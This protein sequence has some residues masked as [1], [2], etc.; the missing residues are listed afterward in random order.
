MDFCP[1]IQQGLRELTMILGGLSI[2]VVARPNSSKICSMGLQSGDLA[3]CSILVTLPCWRKPRISEHG[4]VWHYRL[5]SGSYPRNVAWQMALRCF[6]KCPCRA[7]R[8]GICRGAQ[9]AIWHHYEKVPR[10][11]PN[12]PQLGPYKPDTFAGSAHQVND[13]SYA[14]HLPGNFGIWTHH[15]RWHAANG[16]LSGSALSVPIPSG[17]GCGWLATG[18]SFCVIRHGNHGTGADCWWFSGQPSFHTNSSSASSRPEHL[19]SDPF[20]PSWTKHGFD[21]VWSSE[22]PPWT[23][24]APSSSG[25]MPPED[26]VDGG[27]NQTHA[28]SNS[29]FPHALTGKHKHFIPDTYKGWT[30]HY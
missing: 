20:G 22:Y 30:G 6:A 8:R 1:F 7:R 15:R 23:C 25:S 21:E 24:L 9:E 28:T 4:E 19:W 27:M 14:C 13:V 17:D 26:A 10:R 18:S 11:V 16:P 12:H 5:G 3:G 2:L 29:T